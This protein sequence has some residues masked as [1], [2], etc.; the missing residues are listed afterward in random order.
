MP[1]GGFTPLL[2]QRG[3]VPKDAGK[4]NLKLFA[5]HTF[6]PELGPQ[7]LQVRIPGTG[8]E[9]SLKA[10]FEFGDCGRPIIGQ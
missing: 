3:K 10:C 8:R 1:T 2:V 6:Q 7:K 5:Y 4:S 9:P